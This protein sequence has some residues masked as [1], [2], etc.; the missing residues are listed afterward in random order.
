VGDESFLAMNPIHAENVFRSW[1]GGIGRYVIDILDYGLIKAKIID[2]PI[3][4]TDT[5]SKIPVIRAF[6][7]RDNPGYS[8]KSLTTFFEKLE[9]IQ[10]AFNDLEFAQK[11][12][13]F[14]EV[15]RLSKEAPFDKKF[16]LDYQ[17]SI[18]DLDKAIR[19]IY[20][21]KELADG[22][23]ITGDMKRELIDQKYTLMISFAQEAL[24]LLE[25][26]EN[27]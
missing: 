10:K 18:K 8:A 19:Q 11:I 27:K 14:E 5:L 22:T 15:E 6:D 9:P 20:N 21:V 2:D 16:M 25:K 7:V 26:Q 1:T 4:P 12:G 24:K 23:K 3:K 17:Q 13:D